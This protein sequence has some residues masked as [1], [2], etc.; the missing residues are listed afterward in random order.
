MK[1][2]NVVAEAGCNHMGDMDIAL[3]LIDIAKECNAKYV[4]FQKR[5]P[6]E[7]ISINIQNKPHP[8]PHNSYGNTYLEHRL[9]L[10]LDIN[11]H[12]ILK[13]H[14]EN[15][16]I[17]YSC[18]VWDMSSANEIVS[19]EPDYIKI[20]SACNMKFNLL[21]YLYEKSKTNVHISLGMTTE[22]ERETIFKYLQDKKS[23][24]VVYWTT[25]EYPV[26]FDRLFLLEIPKLTST[27]EHVGFS[28]HH[29]GIAVDVA[30]YTLGATW[31]ERH[32][33]LDRTWKGTDHAASL[34]PDGLKKLNRN[35]EATRIALSLKGEGITEI[36][37][38]QRNKLRCD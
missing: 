11:K 6:K 1:E 3:K 30:A 18:S 23:R 21:D 25:S 8:C 2:F 38:V 29:L 34:E 28:G 33:T 14:C 32:F 12:A 13:K 36:E 7:C 17:G 16:N 15:I 20:P 27:F 31:I 37:S 22:K 4:K 5:N 10:E 35:L 26:P 9:F 19:L 24:T